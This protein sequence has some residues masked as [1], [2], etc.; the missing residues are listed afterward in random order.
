MRVAY[1][2]PLPPERTGISEYSALLLPAL[3]RLVDVE[4]PKRGARTVLQT[5]RRTSRRAVSPRGC[6]GSA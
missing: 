4:L 1:Y 2:S 5:A 6:S 3:R